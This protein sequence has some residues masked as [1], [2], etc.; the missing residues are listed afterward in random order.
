M[1]LVHRRPESE[2]ISGLYH[3]REN[4]TGDGPYRGSR[5]ICLDRVEYDSDGLLRPVAM[6]GGTAVPNVG[7]DRRPG[8]REAIP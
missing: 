5:Q 2:E 6:T 4:Q 8:S 1:A 3:R 7:I